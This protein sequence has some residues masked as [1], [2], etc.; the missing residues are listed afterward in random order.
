MLK[1]WIKTFGREFFAQHAGLFL[2]LFYL[3]FGAVPN[4][5]LKGYILALGININSSPVAGAI[6]M[7]I[8]LLF[9]LKSLFFVQKLINTSVYNFVK[10]STAAVKKIQLL[11]W[12][13]LYLFL[14]SP[15]VIFG[16]FVIVTGM[17]GHFYLSAAA[18]TGFIILI[19]SGL[20]IFTFRAVNYTFKPARKLIT[21]PQISVSKKKPYWTWP[22]HY[23]LKEQPLTL[24]VCKI[25][26]FFLFKGIIWMFADNGNDVR[27]YLLSLM[28]ATISH[29]ILISIVLRFE[30][31]KANFINSLPVNYS[32]KLISLFGFLLALLIPELIF[33]SIVSGFSTFNTILGILLCAGILLTLR[34]S[35]YLVNDDAERY[36][37]Y[38]FILL[39]GSIMA[40]IARL[41]FP[42]SISL[43]ASGVIYHRYLYKKNRL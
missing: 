19:F 31:S 7:L 10:T 8:T 37:K 35:L 41:Y 30:R 23:I 22:L 1:L 3:I 34:M 40:I 5:Q 24:I 36:L 29:C 32:Y 43:I 17:Y 33:Y 18:L 4:S 16:V 39:V 20:S 27:I 14:N 28:A 12:L 11:N 42:F 25:L 38:I 21:L 6:F 15:L 13:V 26:S 2:F 9:S